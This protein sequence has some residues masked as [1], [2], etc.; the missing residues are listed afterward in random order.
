MSGKQVC[1]MH[2]SGVMAAPFEQKGAAADG[3]FIVNSRLYWG[4][5][6]QVT[7]GIVKQKECSTRGN[8]EDEEGCAICE[9]DGSYHIQGDGQVS[10]GLRH[11]WN[12]MP[13]N[14]QECA[15]Y[16]L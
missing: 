3:D 1:I 4:L 8:D 6:R 13:K 11:N 14:N 2:Y 5:E 16:A 15:S 7:N 9:R 12:V 10:E